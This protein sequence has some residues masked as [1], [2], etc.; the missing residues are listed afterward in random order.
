MSGTVSDRRV[1]LI[2]SNNGSCARTAAPAPPSR[3]G[4]VMAH[5]DAS[6]F[7]QIPTTHAQQQQAYMP[8][9]PDAPLQ[10]PQYQPGSPSIFC[11]GNDLP[12]PPLTRAQLSPSS[13][14]CLVGTMCD[15]PP[16]DRQVDCR[17]GEQLAD[18]HQ[19]PLPPLPPPRPNLGPAPQLFLPDAIFRSILQAQ[20]QRRKHVHIPRRPH[21][22]LCA[23]QHR[24]ARSVQLSLQLSPSSLLQHLPP[25]LFPP[26]PCLL[27]PPL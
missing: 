8:M 11:A 24:S 23:P 1:L 27:P 12:Q 3:Y 5:G 20:H 14:K 16:G 4:C 21:L 15:L 22:E 25:R 18:K 10:D 17:Q 6:L 2:A 26:L 19:V 7:G 9:P 13:C